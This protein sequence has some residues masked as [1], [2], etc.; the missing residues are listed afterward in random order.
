MVGIQ[1]W[2]VYDGVLY[3]R[4]Y[5]CHKAEHR[6][7]EE[8]APRLYHKA[9]PY[10]NACNEPGILEELENEQSQPGDGG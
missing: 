9:V 5:K 3:W 10:V 8:D 2:G 4:C 1:V 6:W 7:T